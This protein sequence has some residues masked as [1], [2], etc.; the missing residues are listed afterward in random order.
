[1][2]EN[3]AVVI[4]DQQAEAEEPEEE[5]LASPQEAL[6]AAENLIALTVKETVDAAVEYVVAHEEMEQ[7]SVVVLDQDDTGMWHYEKLPQR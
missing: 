1:V 4:P 6:A 3:P 7:Q 2:Q 5:E